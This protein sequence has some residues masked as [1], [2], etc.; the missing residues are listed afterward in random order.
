V[1]GFVSTLPGVRILGG[2]DALHR[3]VDEDVDGEAF[4]VS[5]L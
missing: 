4:M 1:A 5:I 2:D 3:F